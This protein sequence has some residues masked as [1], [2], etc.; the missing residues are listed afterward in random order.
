MNLI[1]EKKAEAKM[2][3]LL[4]CKKIMGSDQNKK[5]VLF[6]MKLHCVWYIFNYMQHNLNYV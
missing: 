1:H 3:K 2:F 4:F 6:R 5:F